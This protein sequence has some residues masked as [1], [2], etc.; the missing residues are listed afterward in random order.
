MFTICVSFLYFLVHVVVYV[1][2]NC[3]WRISKTSFNCLVCLNN[4]SVYISLPFP[5]SKPGFVYSY[6]PHHLCLLSCV[7]LPPV[8]FI[9]AWG[10]VLGCSSEIVSVTTT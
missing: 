4:E 10:R 1:S 8:V 6:M 7:S 2:P 5:E 9:G 3:V